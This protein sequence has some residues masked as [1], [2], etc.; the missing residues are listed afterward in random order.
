MRLP[1]LGCGL[2][3]ARP[4]PAERESWDTVGTDGIGGAPGGK[5]L[6]DCAFRRQ[7]M[8]M[9]RIASLAAEG[10]ATI[11]LSAL[12]VTSAAHHGIRVHH[13]L[14]R[15]RRDRRC[16][17]VAPPR[18]VM[19]R[20]GLARQSGDW[21]RAPRRSSDTLNVCRGSR[22]Q[23]AA[24]LATLAARWALPRFATLSSAARTGAAFLPAFALCEL[25]LYAVAL[26]ALG[27]KGLFTL[28]SSLTCC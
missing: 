12:I 4:G 18:P 28:A 17:A 10:P 13:A 2:R 25:T 20:R 19:D 16:D 9:V 6:D 14:C 1:I 7:G 21:V 3:R 27:G 23:G 15:V 22:P 8:M 24:L 11:L 26:S 5:S